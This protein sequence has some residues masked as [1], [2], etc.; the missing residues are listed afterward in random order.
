MSLITITP[1]TVKEQRKMS[2]N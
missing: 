1:E 2:N